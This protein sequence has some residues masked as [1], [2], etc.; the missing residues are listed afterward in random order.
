MWGLSPF[1]P[2]C[3]H[4][5]PLV[6]LNKMMGLRSLASCP[7][8]PAWLRVG[9][10]VTISVIMG[11]WSHSLCLRCNLV[12]I[13]CGSFPHPKAAVLQLLILCKLLLFWAPS[14]NTKEHQGRV[15]NEQ[16][17]EWH[18]GAWSREENES[19]AFPESQWALYNATDFSDSHVIFPF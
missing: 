4:V 5:G 16:A 18:W 19:S 8:P 1:L 10:V 11:V 13:K 7:L 14:R 3:L 2:V 15:E 9:L 12:Y 6:I 17:C